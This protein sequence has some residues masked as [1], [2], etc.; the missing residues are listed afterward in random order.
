VKYI[1]Q[2]L[3]LD[4]H[5]P[6]HGERL[7]GV[8]GDDNRLAILSLIE[9]VTGWVREDIRDPDR[10]F[11]IGVLL[12]FNGDQR[13]SQFFEAAYRLAG[14]G[15]HLL[16]FLRP[17]DVKDDAVGP[18]GGQ[19]APNGAQSPPAPIEPPL[20]LDA[21]PGAALNPNGVN[22]PA[23]ARTSPPTPPLPNQ[24]VPFFSRPGNP[25]PAPR[26]PQNPRWPNR[27]PQNP[28]NAGPPAEAAPQPAAPATPALPVPPLPVPAEP[29]PDGPVLTPPA[30]SSPTDP[31]P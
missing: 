22:A 7:E 27:G 20:S 10:L 19:D 25:A 11:L 23:P 26:F 6:A 31:I 21:I 2:G 4:P 18:R 9:R 24:V 14:S 30:N 28:P 3:D 17:A 16:A 8:F 29:A 13:A 1:K 12:H 15:D 5:W